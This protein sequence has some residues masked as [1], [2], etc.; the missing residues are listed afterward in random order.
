MIVRRLAPHPQVAGI[1]K[2]YQSRT[3]EPNE[4]MRR[5]ALP[6]R[7]DV[8]LE[9][10]FTTP[11]L[12]ELQASRMLERA[13]QVAA[14]GPQTF[15]RV[16]LILSGLMNIFTI[17]FAPTGLHVLLGVPM[18]ELTDAG[19]DAAAL[20]G[21]RTIEDLHDRL[22]EATDFADRARMADNFILIRLADRRRPVVNDAVTSTL[23]RIGHT[24]GADPTSVL[25]KQTGLSERQFRRVFAQ[26][27]G[28]APK[29]Y[30][31][32][33]RLEAA[34]TVKRTT[35]D[36]SW[37]DIA[38]DCGW[39]DQAHMDKDFLALAG[40]PPSRFVAATQTR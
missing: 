10:Y 8:L 27:V 11:H 21:R 5:I 38:H 18:T 36:K 30:A 20:F 2:H 31:R 33:V 37:T 39:F 22:T 24:A 23:V 34:L 32:I 15:R 40:T 9:F 29:R 4:P 3:A 28:M 26:Q 7:T 17:H 13:P 12:L 14:V 19:V 6:A 25:A 16:D 1:V 35:P